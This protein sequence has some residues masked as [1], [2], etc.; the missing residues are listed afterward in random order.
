MRSSIPVRSLRLGYPKYVPKEATA[1]QAGAAA[2][3][4]AGWRLRRRLPCA[5][6]DPLADADFDLRA[7]S[8]LEGGRL[9]A[10][11]VTVARS[12][13]PDIPTVAPWVDKERALPL[14][15]VENRRSLVGVWTLCGLLT[16]LIAHPGAVGKTWMVSDAEDVFTPELVRRIARAMHLC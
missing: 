6:P 12:E 15:A 3:W 1:V 14:G 7:A 13:R 9:L 5:A 10:E 16:R 4:A 2:G 11:T 8:R